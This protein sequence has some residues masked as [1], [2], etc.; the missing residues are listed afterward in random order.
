MPEK[1]NPERANFLKNFLL[2]Y[3]S[4]VLTYHLYIEISAQHIFALLLKSKIAGSL[5]HQPPI[6]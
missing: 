3:F 2:L 6:V 5:L 1:I 4:S